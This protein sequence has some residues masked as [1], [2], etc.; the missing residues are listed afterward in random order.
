MSNPTHNA[1]QTIVA[2][3]YFNSGNRLYRRKISQKE[4]TW[5]NTPGAIQ[6]VVVVLRPTLAIEFDFIG[7]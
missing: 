1:P 3:A 2:D 4:K 7:R 5:A 6:D